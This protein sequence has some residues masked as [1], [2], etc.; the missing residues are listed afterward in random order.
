MF[1]IDIVLTLISPL[2]VIGCWALGY[3]LKHAVKTDVIN[4]FIPLILMITGIISNIWSTGVFSYEMV[5]AGAISGLAATGVY[6]A[7]SN[8]LNLSSE[9]EKDSLQPQHLK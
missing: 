5:V 7:I 6:E 9:E 2:I 4:P 8:I 3:V 1:D